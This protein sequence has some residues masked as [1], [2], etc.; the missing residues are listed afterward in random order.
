MIWENS[1]YIFNCYNLFYDKNWPSMG[2]NNSFLLTIWVLQSEKLKSL[3]SYPSA[4]SKSAPR[5]DL[6]HPSTFAKEVLCCFRCL[7]PCFLA[8]MGSISLLVRG[9]LCYLCTS[10]AQLLT[11]WHLV[12]QARLKARKRDFSHY[13]SFLWSFQGLNLQTCAVGSDLES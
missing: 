6:A 1:Q 3:K 7:V 10:S 11:G 13:F 2:L 4:F 9:F 8:C 12:C 5:G